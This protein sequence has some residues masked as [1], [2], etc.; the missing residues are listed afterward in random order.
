[1]VQFLLRNLPGGPIR[2]IEALRRHPLDAQE[3][4]LRSLLQRARGTEWGRRLGFEAILESADVIGA[5]QASVPLHDYEAFRE[6]V[7]RIRRGEPDITWPG[8]F[9]DFAVS[10]G[11][12][13]A[14]EI[15]HVSREM[16]TANR[17]FSMD[18]MFNYVALTGNARIGGGRFLSLPGR[19]EEDPAFPGTWIGEVSGLQARYAPAVV[20]RFYQAVGDDVLNEPSWERK[21]ERIV[22]ATIDM[23]VRTLAMVPT[24]ALV[25]FERL[26][27][28]KRERGERAESL[29]DVWPNLTVFFSGGVALSSYR[30]ILEDQIGGRGI[31]FIESYGASEGFIAFQDEPSRRDMLLHVRN[32]VFFEFIPLDGGSDAGRV[33]LRDVTTDV[34]YELAVT[35]CSGL[36][37]YRIGDV[38]RFT[39]TDPYRLVVAGRTSEMIDKYGEAVF[40]DEVRAALRAASDE[41]GAQ[42]L[43]FHVAPSEPARNRIPRHQWII[44]FEKEPADM[45]VFVR[46][47]DAYLKEHNRHYFIRRDALAFDAPEVVSVS[48]GVFYEWLTEARDT[49]SAQ[50][51]MPRM[52]EERGVADGLLLSLDRQRK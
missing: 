2:R 39:G 35:T 16:L 24:W 47:I 25:L 48:K 32:G 9:S 18:L 52:S 6:D 41:T 42:V 8:T 36:W 12:A 20:S 11:R 33:S 43:E 1:M 29:L 38:V 51:K 46:V 13:S 44:E 31:D 3:E 15:I 19:I 26:I 28:R 17:R 34:R 21:L 40:G 49:V 45:E 14:G 4:M 22:D 30:A 5:Y 23:D 7:T 10:S 27:A 37:S 50:T